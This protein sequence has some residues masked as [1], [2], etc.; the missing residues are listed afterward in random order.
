MDQTPPNLETPPPAPLSPSSSLPAR[1]MNVIASPGEVFDEVKATPGTTSNWVVPALIASVL[2]IAFTL[3]MFSQPAIQRQMRQQQEKA[4]E[5]QVKAGKMTQQ[6]ADQAME[7]TQKFTGPIMKIVGAVSAVFMSFIKLFWWALVLWL[8]A[9]WF[10]KVDVPYMKAVEVAG[11]A[12]IIVV[13]GGIVALLLMVIFGKMFASASLALLVSEFDITN[14]MHFLLATVNV[15]NFW[16]VAV[17]GLGLA[18]LTGASFG[19][20]TLCFLIYWVAIS[21]LLIA[22]GMGQFAL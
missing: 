3:V 22:I 15:F 9:R 13:L 20:A 16:F 10:L 21:L 4:F 19:R 8:I 12:S 14:K 17:M 6:Q 18:R 11:L 2:G 7:M 1:L 5:Q